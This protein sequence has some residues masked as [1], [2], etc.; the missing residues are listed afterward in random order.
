MNTLFISFSTQWVSGEVGYNG[1]ATRIWK[2]G[3]L[4]LVKWLDDF[5]DIFLFFFFVKKSNWN[6]KKETQA[7]S[8]FSNSKIITFDGPY[9]ILTQIS[10][11]VS[12]KN[13]Q[14]TKQFFLFVCIKI[15]FLCKLLIR[16]DVRVYTIPIFHLNATLEPLTILKALSL[17]LEPY[18]H[19]LASFCTWLQLI[20]D[21][22]VAG[23]LSAVE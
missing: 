4:E 22:N 8:K 21:V 12:K 23:V 13:K 20:R 15:C 18:I 7:L 10:S 5:R 9:G 19:I 17:S 16:N 3:G 14:E 11:L 1:V 2:W 6:I